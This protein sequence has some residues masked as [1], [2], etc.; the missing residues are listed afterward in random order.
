MTGRWV[1]ARV[2][3]LGDAA[4]AMTPDLGQGA[5]MAIEDA[6]VLADLLAGEAEDGQVDHA[7]AAYRTTASG[8]WAGCRTP[9]APPGAWPS[10]APVRP[11]ACAR[12]CSGPCPRPSPSAGWRTSS[13]P[14]RPAGPAEAEETK[15]RGAPGERWSGATPGTP[16]PRSTPARYP[17]DAHRVGPYVGLVRA[18]ETPAPSGFETEV[19]HHPARS[20][21]M[22]LALW[23]IAGV[24]AVAGPGLGIVRPGAKEPEA[25]PGSARWPGRTRPG[26]RR[27]PGARSAPATAGWRARRRAG[28]GRRRGPAASARS[29][30]RARRR[31]GEIGAAGRRRW[32]RARAGVAAPRG[33]A[34]APRVAA[35]RCGATVMAFAAREP[36]RRS[37]VSVATGQEVWRRGCSPPGRRG[38]RGRACLPE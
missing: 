23:I 4:H 6:V 31:W 14:G 20:T 11:S 28:C 25:T 7:L 34:G 27:E 38:K 33:R 36:V 37:H 8:G 22:N 21:L 19:A 18:A 26:P 35:G 13:W 2:A 15:R 12:S 9:P 32:R 10:G 5:G 16:R 17:C 24:L 3:L 1:H 30:G 29:A